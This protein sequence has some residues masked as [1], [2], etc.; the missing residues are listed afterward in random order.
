MKPFHSHG[1]TVWS[2]MLAFGDIG[3]YIF[4][5]ET[6]NAVT[7]TPDRSDR[8]VNMVNEFFFPHLTLS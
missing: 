1:V 6:G 2:G 7:V 5:D 3:P 4:E 8:Y